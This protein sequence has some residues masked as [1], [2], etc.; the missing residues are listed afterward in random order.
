MSLNDFNE[1]LALALE[2]EK[3]QDLLRLYR[4]QNGKDGKP[5][6]SGIVYAELGSNWITLNPGLSIPAYASLIACSST[7]QYVIACNDNSGYLLSISKDFGTTWSQNDGFSENNNVGCISCNGKIIVLAAI[8]GNIYYSTDGGT[9]WHTSDQNIPQIVSICCDE[10]GKMLTMCSGGQ[11]NLGNLYTSNNNGVTWSAKFPKPVNWTC[12]AMNKR[13]NFRVACEYNGFIFFTRDYGNTWDTYSLLNSWLCIGMSDDQRI[14]AIGTDNGIFVS[15]NQLG[16]LT[17]VTNLRCWF[18]QVSSCGKYM[19]AAMGESEIYISLDCGSTWRGVHNIPVFSLSMS[20]NALYI[21]ST[22]YNSPYVCSMCTLRGIPGIE[23]SAGQQGDIGETGPTEFNEIIDSFKD[24]CYSYNTNWRSLTSFAFLPSNSFAVSLTS[25]YATFIYRVGNN[26]NIYVSHDYGHTFNAHFIS[27]IRAVGTT[28]VAVSASGEYQSVVLYD[29]D[30]SILFCSNDFGKTFTRIN[31]SAQIGITWNNKLCLTMSYDGRYQYLS[32]GS[33]LYFSSDFGQNWTNPLIQTLLHIYAID[34]TVYYI[35][36]VTCGIVMF[37]CVSNTFT[38]ISSA[39]YSLIDYTCGLTVSHDRK[40]IAV[41]Y[42]GRYPNSNN[43]I[44]ISNNYG[45][46]FITNVF[47]SIQ[48]YTMTANGKNHFFNSNGLVYFSTDY[49]QNMSLLYNPSTT[50]IT[51][52][53]VDQSGSNLFLVNTDNVLFCMKPSKCVSSDVVDSTL[54]MQRSYCNSGVSF[55]TISSSNSGQV[56]IARSAVSF[57]FITNNFGYT[58]TVITPGDLRACCV[59]PSGQYCAY[60]IIPTSGVSGVFISSNYG[61][62]FDEAS[63]QIG[64][65]LVDFTDYYGDQTASTVNINCMCIDDLGNLTVATQQDPFIIMY[66]NGDSWTVLSNVSTVG[67]AD[68]KVKGNYSIAVNQQNVYVALNQLYVLA[69]VP[70]MQWYGC[71]LSANGK[72]MIVVSRDSIFGSIWISSDF[73]N[74]W[75]K[76]NAEYHGWRS[77]AMNLDASRQVA[78]FQDVANSCMY[79]ST[80]F[81]LNW[82]FVKDSILYDSNYW[83]QVAISDVVTAVV[84]GSNIKAGLYI[85]G[86]CSDDII[87]EPI[88]YDSLL[89]M[90]NINSVGVDAT[91]QIGYFCTDSVS[92]YHSKKF[93]YS[94]T[95]YVDDSASLITIKTSKSGQYVLMADVNGDVKYSWDGG[96]NFD[97][98]DNL[99]D[100]FPSISIKSIINNT[101]IA[102]IAIS[103]N[104][105]IQ[106]LLIS[107]AMFKSVNYGK[108]WNLIMYDLAMSNPTAVICS[109]NGRVVCMFTGSYFKIS[110]NYG[111]KFDNPILN[112]INGNI[113]YL[114]GTRNVAMSTS[115]RYIYGISTIYGF[116]RSADFGKS[117]KQILLFSYNP[118]NNFSISCDNSGKYVSFSYNNSNATFSSNYGITVAA[119]HPE[120][121]EF[122]I[123]VRVNSDASYVFMNTNSALANTM[124][125]FNN[126][127]TPTGLYPI[128][129]NAEIGYNSDASFSGTT[130]FLAI[131]N[132]QI[133]DEILMT[134]GVY[135][136]TINVTVIFGDDF[137]TVNSMGFNFAETCSGIDYD[138]QYDI[139]IPSTALTKSISKIINIITATSY[140]V[141]M[142][143]SFTTGSFQ[144]GTD[145]KLVR[146]A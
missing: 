12:V 89:K 70:I 125:V 74:S 98:I 139:P 69:N 1:N 67:Y 101:K 84:N 118:I 106:Y 104:G 54:W 126:Y 31:L 103:D 138:Y 72:C 145:I 53:Y 51:Y 94:T 44:A 76:S 128:V 11:Y 9:N 122:I 49:G 24:V 90:F 86:D 85:S 18:I 132:Y 63:C 144:W 107:Q 116:I 7:G 28:S 119:L 102:I 57:V 65:D 34:N 112:Q 109:G 52:A 19:S 32:N 91:H 97:Y 136:A 58:W 56:K 3:I 46:T 75:F 62:S 100:S 5:G 26:L 110:W 135:V 66:Y 137:N 36:E 47:D 22:G 29:D 20:S 39:T 93:L 60:A 130:S 141:N 114:D 95:T 14:I 129:S 37:D 23:G 8:S 99:T 134:P 83:S 142:Y 123:G 30:D 77:I 71:D 59:S 42:H 121:T 16:T 4:G 6:D 25:K 40:Y 146:I 108:T 68:L 127:R 73:G 113:S 41:S 50:L 35:D 96:S 33:L 21:F 133:S 55:D 13:G 61:I 64:N 2:T 140:Y 10:T 81:G 124:Y 143:G 48:N 131:N 78:V 80:D 17:Q 43:Y 92:V 82:S 120:I 117:W 27:P 45:G 105:M 38:E 115:G 88:N 87:V 111:R 79:E 15:T